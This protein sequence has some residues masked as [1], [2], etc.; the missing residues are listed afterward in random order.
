MA[1]TVSVLQSTFVWQSFGVIDKLLCD[2]YLLIWS[3]LCVNHSVYLGA[4]IRGGPEL[5]YS[6][7]PQL[8]ASAYVAD[9]PD[10]YF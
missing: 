3:L 9:S 4:D 5:H 10:T 6:I 7:V 1:Q 8:S 2:T